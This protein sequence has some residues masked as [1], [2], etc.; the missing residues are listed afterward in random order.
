MLG[1][2]FTQIWVILPLKL[3]VAVAKQLLVNEKL[4]VL[5]NAL[6]VDMN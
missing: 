4:F 1:F 3:W 2:N 5:C 6:R